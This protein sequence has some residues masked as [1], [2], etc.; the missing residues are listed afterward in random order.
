MKTNLKLIALFIGASFLIS[1]SKTETTSQEVQS[2]EQT[3][4]NTA[5]VE[6]VKVNFGF[7]KAQTQTIYETYLEM[8]DALVATDFNKTQ[9][10]AKQL[11]A[12]LE[13]IGQ[14]EGSDIIKKDADLIANATDVEKQREA[15]YSLSRTIY[16]LTKTVKPV[17]SEIYKQYCPMAF[18]DKGA[19]WLSKDKEIKNP[20]FG[21]K[22]LT[23]GVVEEKF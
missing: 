15:F 12:S 5:P 9:M 1:C 23:C 18:N 8:K 3:T 4:I 6:E 2:T 11:G 17:D 16:A 13:S 20:Y 10:A 7:D 22:M 21:D 14:K 19:F